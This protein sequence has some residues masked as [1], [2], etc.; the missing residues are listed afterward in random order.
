MP[1]D[2]GDSMSE[3]STQQAVLQKAKEAFEDAI[4]G[5]FEIRGDVLRISTTAGTFALYIKKCSDRED[6]HGRQV[7]LWSYR[8]VYPNF[9]NLNDGGL[10]LI[11]II[12]KLNQENAFGKTFVGQDG[13]VSVDVVFALQEN[14]FD[15]FKAAFMARVLLQNVKEMHEHLEEKEVGKKDRVDLPSELLKFLKSK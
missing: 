15:G 11:P 10:Q 8:L 14:E 6:K 4:T 13:D 2:S 5:D 7:T 9:T 12:N 1:I 3:E